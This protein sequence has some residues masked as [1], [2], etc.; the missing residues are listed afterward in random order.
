MRRVTDTKYSKLSRWRV[1]R[2]KFKLIDM[3][4][5]QINF[6]H[7]YKDTFKTMEGAIL[8]LLIFLALA[9]IAGI[10]LH[11]MVKRS[12]QILNITF[13]SSDLFND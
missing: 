12:E 11:N 9:I 13:E 3:F 8:T 1:L 10:Y 2:Q 6:T 4:G 5:S 7:K